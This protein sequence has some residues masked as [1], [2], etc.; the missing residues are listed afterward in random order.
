[1]VLIGVTFF[2]LYNDFKYINNTT[3]NNGNIPK[4]RIISI[5]KNVCILTDGVQQKQ[6][7]IP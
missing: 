3:K 5:I 4:L 6:N 2:M 1:M 7:N